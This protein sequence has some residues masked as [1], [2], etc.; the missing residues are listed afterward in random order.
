MMESSSK[1][2]FGFADLTPSSPTLDFNLGSSRKGHSSLLTPNL[3]SGLTPQLG[4]SMTPSFLP[5]R[6]PRFNPTSTPLSQALSTPM[7]NMSS[8]KLPAILTNNPYELRRSPRLASRSMESNSTKHS[9]SFPHSLSLDGGSPD[10]DSVVMKKEYSNDA[11]PTGM[12]ILN[13]LQHSSKC[14]NLS[15]SLFIYLSPSLSVSVSVSLSLCLCLSLCLSLS[16]SLS[17][18]LSLSAC[19]SI[20]LILN[21]PLT[22]LLSLLSLLPPLSP[23]F[24]PSQTVVTPEVLHL[25]PVRNIVVRVTM[26][27]TNLKPKTQMWCFNNIHQRVVLFIHLN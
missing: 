13:R 25:V 24:S 21:N 16:L 12:S 18:Y 1:S 5:R 3:S 15:L 20:S 23:P 8:P 11:V 2:S 27:W 14:L 22:F 19:L 17:L 4:A 26:Y 7:F 10:L 6:S 9:A